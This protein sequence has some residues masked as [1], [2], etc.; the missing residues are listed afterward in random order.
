M[1]LLQLRKQELQVTDPKKK[2]Q[3]AE[4]ISEIEN[5]LGM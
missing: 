5:Q 3:L 1:Q 2:V 4:R